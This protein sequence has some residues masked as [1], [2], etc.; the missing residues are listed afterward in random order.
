MLKEIDYFERIV[1][2]VHKF[3]DQSVDNSIRHPFDERNVHP[4]FPLK[5]K[6]LF[7]DGHFAEA[8]FE[9]A[10]Y[11]DKEIQRISG[12]QKSGFALIMSVFGGD[13]PN[14]KLNAMLNETEKDE[15]RGYQF[16]IAGIM[17]AIR[18]PR[19][20]EHS[21]MD[22]LDVCLDHLVLISTCIRRLEQSGYKFT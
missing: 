13:N 21:M 4:C 2:D 1:R 18:N 12:D 19:G 16:I 11:L 3:T 15:Q 6:A 9:A 8:T 14:L 20:H 5:V 10:K 22:N 17:S 7:D